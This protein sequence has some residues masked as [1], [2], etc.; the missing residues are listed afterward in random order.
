MALIPPMMF[1]RGHVTPVARI[2]PNPVFSLLV[3][4]LLEVTDQAF[5]QGDNLGST[6]RVHASPRCRQPGEGI[7]RFRRVPVGYS[8]P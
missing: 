2:S 5:S 6:C 3:V 4:R 8:G 1:W 7:A